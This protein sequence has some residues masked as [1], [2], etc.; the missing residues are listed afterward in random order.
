[1]ALIEAVARRVADPREGDKVVH[2]SETTLRQRVIAL[3]AGWEDLNDTANLRTDPVHEV[4]MERRTR[5][6]RVRRHCAG[7]RTGRIGRR[8]GR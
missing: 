5:P 2:E 8:H 7:S 6:W 1:M 3:V 4:A